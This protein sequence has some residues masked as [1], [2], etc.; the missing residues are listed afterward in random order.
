MIRAIIIDDERNA[1]KVLDWAL[2][3][4]C[5]E[6]SIETHCSSGAEALE[7]IPKIK[8]DLVF[9]DIQMRDMTGFD[10]LAKLDKVNFEIIFTTAFNQYALD[11]F[12]VSAV[13]YLMKPIDETDLQ[14]AVEKVKTRLDNKRSNRQ[15]SFL[16]DYLHNNIETSEKVIAL[17]SQTGL[18]FI[19]LEQIIY[20]QSDSNY[21]HLI[22]TNNKKMLVSKTLKDIEAMLPQ[23]SFFRVHNSFIVNLKYIRRY[24]K[25]DGGYLIMSNDDKVK[26][27]RTKKESLFEMF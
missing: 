25:A 15:I 21:T 26:V 22:F 1:R 23:K 16:L 24:L 6:V 17:P 27:S 14:K 8:P 11:A 4:Y 13:D 19:E 18:E 7:Q 10:V 2:K 5:P 3:T 9:L 20:C 12:K